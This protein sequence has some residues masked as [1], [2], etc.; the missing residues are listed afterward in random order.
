MY[1]DNPCRVELHDDVSAAQVADLG[2]EVIVPGHGPLT[3]AAGVTAV[4][5]YLVF[6]NSIIHIIVFIFKQKPIKIL[7][8]YCAATIG[9]TT[10]N[11]RCSGEVIFHHF[12]Q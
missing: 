8:I 11:I 2:A 1:A 12:Q 5:D 10:G 6:V 4:R 7:F 3:D 9:Y